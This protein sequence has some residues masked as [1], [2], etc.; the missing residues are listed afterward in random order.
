MESGIKNFPTN[1]NT[2]SHDFISKF[3]Q[4]FKDLPILFNSCKILKKRECFWTHLRSQHYPDNK[5]NMH[6]T[7]KKKLHT[8]ILNEHR[9]KNLYKILANLF[10]WISEGS[11]TMIKW[12]LFQGMQESFDIHKSLDVVCCINKMKDEDCMIL[13]IDAKKAFDKIQHL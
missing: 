4:I 5:P 3:Y 9:Y 13:S 10:K 12:N 11:Y 1:K 6:T 2:G 8:N 7:E